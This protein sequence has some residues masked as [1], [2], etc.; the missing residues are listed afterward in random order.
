MRKKTRFRSFDDA[1]AWLA[2][3]TNYETMAVQR[4]DARTYGLD[5]VERLLA[6]VGRPDRAFDV[7]QVLGSKGKGS[8][9]TALAS[10]AATA[11]AS[12]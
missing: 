8:T 12:P 10:F 11:R 1:F 9:A 6:A 4:Y 5:R 2:A 3:R 7:V